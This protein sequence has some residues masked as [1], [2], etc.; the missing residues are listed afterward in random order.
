[1]RV[2]DIREILVHWDGGE[3]I[4][5][6]AHSLGY[7]RPTVRKYARA[8]QRAGLCRGSRGH[9]ETAWDQLAATVLA[10]VTEP[11]PPGTATAAVAGYHAYLAARIGEVRLSVLYQRLCDEQGLQASWRTFY[12]YVRTHWPERV[13]RRPRVTVRLDDPPPGSEAQ[14]DFCYLGRWRDPGLGRERRVYGFLMTLSHSRHQFWYPVLAEDGAAWL[15]GHV[16]AFAFFAGAPRRLVPDN[17]TAGILKADR[18]DPRV[19][20]AYGEL[21]R[22]YG[23]LIDPSRVAHPQDKPRVERNVAYARESFF[24]GRDFASLAAMREA[25][26]RWARDLAGQRLHGTTRERPLTAF[27]ARE[28]AALLPLPARPWEPVRWTTAKVQADCHLQ[29][30]SARY[31]VPYRYVG[32]PL[33]VRLGRATVEIYAGTTLVTSHVRRA[34]GR[35][36]RLEHYP[37]ASQAF[38]RATPP[39]CRER[40]QGL[41]GATAA[42]VDTLLTPGTLTGLREAQAV[43]RLAERYPPERLAGACERALAAGDGRYRTVRGILERD[44]DRVPPEPSPSPT[45]ASAFLRGLASLLATSREGR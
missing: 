39:V 33:D 11:R 17:L 32:Q 3:P 18:Y 38:L 36:T 34:T 8:A 45:R 24:R 41:G 26:A 12:R 13:P 43:L 42:L 4:A 25:A 14:V 35:A 5:Q 9:D 23:C 2:A 15:E 22:Y 19:N 37:A 30:A 28:Q 16:A 10:A 29:V 6:I 7:S 44:L 20:R 21:G 27:L 31:S 1:M 40:A